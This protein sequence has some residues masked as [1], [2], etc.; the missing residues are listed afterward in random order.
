MDVLKLS[1]YEFH[2]ILGIYVS[3]AWYGDQEAK[4]LFRR[5]GLTTILQ[6]VWEKKGSPLLVAIENYKDKKLWPV[7]PLFHTGFDET[8]ENV[9]KMTPERP[10]EIFFSKLVTVCAQRI[11]LL[12][13]YLELPRP[14][15]DLIWSIFRFILVHKYDVVQGRRIDHILI[16]A[17]YFVLK[18]V[19]GAN[20]S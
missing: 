14:F 11:N 5:I 4:V 13:N 9:Q 19:A 18:V 12:C 8:G 7:F 10:L 17:T 20:I 16:S 15:P 1:A 2:K 6:I 3:T